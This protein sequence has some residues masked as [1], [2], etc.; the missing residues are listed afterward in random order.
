MPPPLTHLH[1]ALPRVLQDVFQAR[2]IDSDHQATPAKS[3][4]VPTTLRV[5]GRSRRETTTPRRLKI[6]V[7]VRYRPDWVGA[8]VLPPMDKPRPT[9]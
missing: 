7:A 3:I 5:V 8:G 4:S 1:I 2:L 9:S 6:E